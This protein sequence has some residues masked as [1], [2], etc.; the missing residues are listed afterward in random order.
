MRA[1][2]TVY[3]SRWSDFVAHTDALEGWAFR[4]QRAANWPLV[5][6]L[7]RRLGAFCPDARL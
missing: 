4:G 1:M 6:T 2:K 5:S 3:I 7:T